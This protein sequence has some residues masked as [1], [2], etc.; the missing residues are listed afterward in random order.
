M[1]KK[2][3]IVEFLATGHSAK[4]A[5]AVFG[6][7]IQYAYQLKKRYDPKKIE[8]V[9]VALSKDYLLK[10]AWT[11]RHLDGRKPSEIIELLASLPGV[12][13]ELIETRKIIEENQRKAKPEN[14]TLKVEVKRNN[15]KSWN[16]RPW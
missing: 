2:S 6:V 13:E 4:E 1:V 12:I 8:Q 14:E 15:G 9:K 10:A 3:E 5:S 7:T 11:L 16:V